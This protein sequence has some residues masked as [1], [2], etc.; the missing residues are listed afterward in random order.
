MKTLIAYATKGGV[1]GESAQVI[2]QVFK[3][4]YSFDVDVINL[5]KEKAP[6]IAQY[7]NVV[8]GSGIRMGR[9]YKSALKMLERDLAG[10]K[11]VLFLSA[12]SAGDP[13]KH[14]E[15]VRNYLDPVLAKYPHMKPVAAQAFGGRMRMLG[16]TVE[17][18]CD[19]DKIREWAEEVGKKLKEES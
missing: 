2:A 6:D 1:T 9:W 19:M 3:E 18:N 16:K 17:D 14:D 11:V 15:A 13:K 8:I 7:T 4:K 5:R 12:C 10:K